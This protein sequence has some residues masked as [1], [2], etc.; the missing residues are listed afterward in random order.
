[1]LQSDGYEA[2]R[3]FAA[4][5]EDVELLACWA[6]A[7]RKLRDAL[8]ADRELVLPAM[9]LIGRLYELEERWDRLGLADSERELARGSESLP[10]AAEI[11]QELETIAADLSVLPSSA[12]HK[13]AAYALKRWDA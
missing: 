9:K 12:A 6:H 13:A 3:S 4:G 1:Q 5:R 10:V 8:A 2:Y 7:F 11:R